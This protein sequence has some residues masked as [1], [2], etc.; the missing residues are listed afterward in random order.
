VAPVEPAPVPTP[1]EPKVT[2]ITV[3]AGE[4]VIVRGE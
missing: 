1:S 4:T 2:T 3:R